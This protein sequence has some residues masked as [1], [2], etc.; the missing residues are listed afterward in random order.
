VHVLL[1]QIHNR[2]NH[3]I[4]QELLKSGLHADIFVILAESS[5]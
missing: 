4:N 3:T 5:R 1:R 2:G